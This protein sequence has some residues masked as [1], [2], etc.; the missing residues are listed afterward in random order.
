MHQVR[1]FEEEP[2]RRSAAKLLSKDEARRIAVNIAKLPGRCVRV[3]RPLP[4]FPATRVGIFWL[5]SQELDAAGML[6]CT[7]KNKSACAN[8]DE[9]RG[10]FLYGSDRSAGSALIPTRVVQII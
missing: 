3:F 4:S 6:S 1:H 5:W 10:Q 8:I 9:R 2:G 7:P